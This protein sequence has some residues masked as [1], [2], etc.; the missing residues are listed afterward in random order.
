MAGEAVSVRPRL[1]EV[2]AVAQHHLTAAHSVCC[3]VL[4]CAVVRYSHM[5]EPVLSCSS[6]L[7]VLCILILWCEAGVWLMT[8][9]CSQH[10]AGELGH[11]LLSS[12]RLL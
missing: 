3:A 5:A 8:V 1:A 11:P 4:G 6:E 12:K 9:C 2:E 10:M 7:R